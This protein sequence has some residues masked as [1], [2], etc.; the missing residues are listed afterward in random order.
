MS[1]FYLP[2]LPIQDR[3]GRVAFGQWWAPA[4]WGSAAAGG[5]GKT[6]RTAR[7]FDSPT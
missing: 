7:A 3:G 6:E 2:S 5:E 1:F 4:S